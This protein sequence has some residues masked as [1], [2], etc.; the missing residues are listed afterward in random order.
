MLNNAKGK[1]FGIGAQAN[2]SF[3]VSIKV[4]TNVC[5]YK[6]DFAT[7]YCAAS[8]I[9]STARLRCNDTSS[10][11]NGSVQFLINPKLENRLENEPTIWVHPA[12]TR[13]GW[14]E[15]SYPS[16]FVQKGDTFK[17][18]VGCLADNKLCDVTF[19][20]SYRTSYQEIAY[21]P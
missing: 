17:A 9:S 21:I 14:I 4:V 3:W 2:T 20:L 16:I 10:P 18:W 8:W 13:N 12:Q 15:G 7:S 19:Y 1:L 11:Q 6:Y 5:N